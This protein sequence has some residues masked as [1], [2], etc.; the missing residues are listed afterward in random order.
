VKI[1]AAEFDT[2]VETEIVRTCN[3]HWLVI[4]LS[5]SGDCWLTRRQLA[6]LHREFGRV[7]AKMEGKAK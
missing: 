6:A 2:E 4:S 5:Q 3:G 1:F 7:L